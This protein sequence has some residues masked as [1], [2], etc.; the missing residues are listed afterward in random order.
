MEKGITNQCSEMEGDGVRSFF[1]DILICLFSILS[2]NVKIQDLTPSI[3]PLSPLV[4]MK[5][6]V[7]CVICLLICAIRHTYLFRESLYHLLCH[8]SK[9]VF[10][11]P[12]PFSSGCTVIHV[13]RP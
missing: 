9:V 11:P 2:V 12:P 3:H 10:R 6:T 7:I 4:L 5:E 13:M 1:F 8:C